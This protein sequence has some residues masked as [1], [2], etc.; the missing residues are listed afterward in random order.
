T[1]KILVADRV[2]GDLVKV[3]RAGSAKGIALDEAADVLEAWDNTVG[4]E[5]KG[6]VLFE[7]FWR[8]YMRQTKKPYAVAW[9]EKRPAATP[10]GIGDPETARIALADAVKE[11]REKSGT[12]TIP[13]GEIH[14]LRRGNVDVPIGGIDDSFG[15]VRTEFGAFRIIAYEPVED[16]KFVAR[17]GGTVVIAVECTSPPTAYSICAYSQSEDPRSAHH[18]DQSPLFAQEKWKRVCFTEDDIAKNLERSYHP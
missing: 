1:T 14:R 18:A 7:N 11:V 8:R 10:L 9:D 6:S 5:S 13:W 12:L 3:A 4:R 2:K 15:G 16:G 17:A